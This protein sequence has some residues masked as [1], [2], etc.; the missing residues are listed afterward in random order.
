MNYETNFKKSLVKTLNDKA[1]SQKS[2]NMY[3]RNLELLNDKPLNNLNFLNDYKKILQ[4]LENKNQNTKRSYL[5]SI[6]AVLK[7]MDKTKT[8]SF[9]QYHEEMM[10]LNK[11]I[12]QEASENKPT[13]KQE[14]EW[15]QWPDVI[16]RHKELGQEFKKIVGSPSK[17]EYNHIILPYM[18]LSL[19]VLNPPRRNRDYTEMVVIKNDVKP[20]DKTI[21][22]LILDKDKFY[23]NVFKTSKTAPELE[24]ELDIPPELKSIIND[25]LKYHPLIKNKINNKTHEWFLVNYDGQKLNESNGMTKLLN[26][27]FNKEFAASMLRH[28]YLTYK[29]FDITEQMKLDSLAM[30]HSVGVQR[31][32]I[33]NVNDTET[34]NDIE[35]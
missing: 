15:I 13:Q 8:N 26:K 32:Y 11:I 14:K 3:V 21:N 27:V 20:M 10:K 31:E 9:K 30:G 18:A 16:K 35:V 12:R 5:I 33:K 22:Y 29:Y 23:F 28:S 17:S 7:H 34:K 25:Y 24:K 1:L 19:Y 4:K 6:V 2:I